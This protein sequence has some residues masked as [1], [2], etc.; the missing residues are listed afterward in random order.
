MSHISAVLAVLA[1]LLPSAALAGEEAAAFAPVKQFVEGFN[2]GDAKTALAACAP[3]A[4]I[5]DEFAPYLWLGAN[6]CST[7]A[8]AYDADAKANGITDGVV[9]LGKPR[10]VFVTGDT[11][12]V[13][14]PTAYDYKR[15]GKKVSQKGAV[16]AVTLQKG[17]DGWRITGWAWATGKN[18]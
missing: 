5:I 15:K 11:A 3:S 1:T 12:Y 17:A 6:A 13:V 10:H 18:G 7:W 14:V 8:G 9:T 2:K 16:M 4:V